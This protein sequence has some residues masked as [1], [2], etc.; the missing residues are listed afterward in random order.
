MS[1]PPSDASSS[2]LHEVGENMSSGLI[3]PILT[4]VM[5]CCQGLALLGPDVEPVGDFLEMELVRELYVYTF[6]NVTK[7]YEI[8]HMRKHLELQTIA[9]L[10]RRYSP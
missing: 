4:E 2:S 7:C 3:P 6:S 1:P 10:M 5:A 9:K 8:M